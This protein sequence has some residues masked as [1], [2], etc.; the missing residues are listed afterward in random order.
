MSSRGFALL[1]DEPRTDGGAQTGP[2]P[3]DYLAAALAS[4]TSMTVRMYADRKQLP[5]EDVITTVDVDRVHAEDWAECEH[6]DGR[7]ERFTRTIA[8][9][10]D[11][12]PDTHACL[13]AIAD[14]CP[15]HRTLEG[16][17]EVHTR[18]GG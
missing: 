8:L 15:V 14:R 6:S 5:L 4:C 1:A 16:Q 18:G 2:P 17:I 7:V 9:R 10:G 12:D 13:L 3:Y 11:L